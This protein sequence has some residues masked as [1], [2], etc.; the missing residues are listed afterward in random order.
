[1]KIINTALIA[2]T[3]LTLASCASVSSPEGGDKDTTPPTLVSSNPK[4][5]QLNVSTRTIS[6]EF[7]EDVQPNNLQ[8][9]LLITPFTENK[10]RIRTDEKVIELNFDTPLQDSTTYTLNFRKGIADITEKNV[11]ENL[12]L[13][14]STGSY[15]DS[16]RV[17]GQVVNLMTQQPEK[18]VI[19][20]LYPAEDTTN[21]RK[22]RPYYQTQTNSSGQFDFKNLR[23]GNYRIYAL[24]D[25]N[26][27]SLYDNEAERIAFIGK[28]ISVKPDSQQVTLET[29][30]IDTKKPIALQRQKFVDRFTVTY[31]EGVERITALTLTTKDTI[32]YKSTPDGKN[33]ELFKNQ[34]FTGGKVLVAAV[35]SAGNSTLD[36]LQVDFGPDY[37]QRL[38]GAN[39]KVI[40]TQNGGQTYRPGQKATIELQTQVRI[41]GTTPVTIQA[42]TTTSITLKYPE[43]LTLDKTA[44]EISFTIPQ[45]KN[46][47]QSY[48]ILLDS[49]QIVPLQGK[50]LKF[51]QIPIT[52]GEAQGTGSLK[53]SITTTQKSFIVQLL[54]GKYNV[55]KEQKNVKNFQFRDLPPGIYLIRILVDEN[56]NGK[57]D[58]GTG[59][60]DKE[61]ERV[62]IH[63]DQVEIRANWELEDIKV[64]L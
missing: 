42:D 63:P 60:F 27:N 19:V 21:I 10:Y 22:S 36:T 26:N 39:L 5:Q 20:A 49:T 16:S 1:M 23:E 28:P 44:T 45:L 8:K 46:R 58:R 4:D 2:A 38:Q 3:L 57:W 47:Q 40:N 13:S 64:Q 43:Q 31:S 62:Y 30:T 33:I 61:P 34:K 52:I 18:D 9:E 24:A 37:T 56:N 55:V 11:V 17:E 25:K 50:P 54:D 29:F 48:M 6:L 41:T 32:L 15:I 51:A 35:D 59:T 53:G 14:F 12:R 7:D